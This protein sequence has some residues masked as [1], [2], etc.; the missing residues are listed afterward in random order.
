MLNKLHPDLK[1][2]IEYSEE[3]LPF[4]DILLIKTNNHISTDIYFKET[5]S[6]QYLNF[7]SCHP[8]HTKT[9]IPYNLA[10]RICTIV[11]DSNVR[12]IRLSELQAVLRKRNYP[13]MLISQ[14]IKKAKSTPRNE[15]LIP[16]IKNDEEVT[17]YVS[18][19]N[20]N[21]TEMF[22]ILK[23]NLHFLTSNQTM[24]DALSKIRK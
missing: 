3:N 2:T 11:S 21:N 23:N 15:L 20:P 14:G 1:F 7:H 6:M 17:S 5:D 9:S 22:S 12:E 13:E 19:Y 16:P 4:L 18:T 10:R 8:K 24:H